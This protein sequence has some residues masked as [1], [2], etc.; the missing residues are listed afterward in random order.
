MLKVEGNDLNLPT[1]W[2][3]VNPIIYRRALHRMNSC[4]TIKNDTLYWEIQ[5][6]A[7]VKISENIYNYITYLWKYSNAKLKSDT[8][9][10]IRKNIQDGGYIITLK[11]YQDSTLIKIDQ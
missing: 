11:N 6:G 5:N 3:K 7:E 8:S 9:Y 10:E 1:E 2:L 4:L